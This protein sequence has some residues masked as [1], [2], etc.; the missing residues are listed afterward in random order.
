[1]APEKFTHLFLAQTP[2]M[3]SM[4]SWVS[5]NIPKILT[6]PVIGQLTNFTVEKR[7]SR[8]WYE[9]ALPEGTDCKDYQGIALNAINTGA[10]FCLAGIVQG[11][12][13]DLNSALKLPSFPSTL[14]WGNKDASHIN[15]DFSSIGEHL[16]GCE[17]IKFDD[18]GHF[19]E[20]EKS[21]TYAKLV[22]ERLL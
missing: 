6:L 21:K 4:Q 13:K 8:R 15:T 17:V 9:K 22:Y 2:G 20:L 18:C 3:H 10:C 5:D 16:P 12:G 11:L 7:L 19:P 1:V 14:I